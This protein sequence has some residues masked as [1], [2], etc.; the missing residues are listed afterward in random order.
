MDAN[1]DCFGEDDM[2][3]CYN[4]MKMYIEVALCYDVSIYCIGVQL[5]IISDERL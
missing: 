3:R 5:I 2:L 4:G 1:R